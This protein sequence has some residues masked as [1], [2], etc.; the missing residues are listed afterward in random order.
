[1]QVTVIPGRTTLCAIALGSGS[2]LAAL[3]AGMPVATG[4]AIALAWT[5]EHPAVTSPVIGARTLTQALD[6]IGAL[7]LRL[8]AAHVA[9]LDAVSRP[10]PIF[11]QRFVAGGMVQQLI[12]GGAAVRRPR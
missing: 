10:D 7:A 12:F 6:N 2:V 9:R 11:P 3:V 5:L 8:D 4:A 1:M